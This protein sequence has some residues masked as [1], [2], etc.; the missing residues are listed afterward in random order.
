MAEQ[1]DVKLYR[2][3]CRSTRNKRFTH[4]MSQVTWFGSQ[5]GFP[6]KLI[7][8]FSRAAG[9]IE[10]KLHTNIPQALG[11]PWH[12]RISDRSHGLAAILD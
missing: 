5:I 8:V 7:K 12:S 4:M 6:L 11:I 2:Y 3:D 10:G 9:Q 1:I